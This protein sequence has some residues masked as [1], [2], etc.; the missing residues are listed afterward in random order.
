MSSQPKNARETAFYVL[1]RAKGGAWSA[2][3]LKRASHSN[4]LSPRDSALCSRIC[5][6]VQQ[7]QLLLDYWIASFSR[8][9]VEK[10]ESAV[11]TALRMGLYQIAL[12]DRVPERAA[13]NES[14]ELVKRSSRNP[15]SSRLTNGILRAFCRQEGDWPPAPA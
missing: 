13:V 1:E 4:D 12:M 5:Y 3:A 11:L 15:N 7:N 2:S 6:G 9:P 8:V 14:V 10:L